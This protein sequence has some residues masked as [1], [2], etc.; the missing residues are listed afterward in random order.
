MLYWTTVIVSQYFI[1]ILAALVG[2]LGFGKHR[3]KD[4]AYA[5]TTAWSAL[6]ALTT[7]LLIGWFV[8][9]PRPFTLDMVAARIDEPLT[10]Y[11]FPS[12]HSSVAFAIAMS[13][14]LAHPWLGA[15]AFVLAFLIGLSRVAVG[16]HYPTDILAG[17]LLG[18][19]AAL[20]IHWYR[21]YLLPKQMRKKK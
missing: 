1:F 21:L 10:Q 6:L 7:S 13:L 19:A 4:R 17:A 12:S 11:S 8:K 16:V 5:Y 3:R 2:V 14:T 20:A 9:R 18:I 15:I